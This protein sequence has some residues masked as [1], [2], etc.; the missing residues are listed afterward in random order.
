MVDARFIA[1][2][3]PGAGL[4]NVG[5]GDL[6]DEPALL[7]GLDAGTPGHAVLDVF[8]R[9]PL[10]KDHPFWRHPSVTV[11]PHCAGATRPEVSVVIVAA[12][13]RAALEGGTPNGLVDRSRGY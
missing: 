5:R 9:E 4:I 6:V 13:L 7:A 3:K 11:T 12:N 10:A 1:A 8:S 2:M